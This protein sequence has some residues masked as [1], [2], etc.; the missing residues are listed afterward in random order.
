MGRAETLEVAG[1]AEITVYRVRRGPGYADKA[2]SPARRHFCRHCGSTLWASDPRWP[3]LVHPFASAIDTALPKAPER[4]H[5]MLDYVP[6]W[7]PVPEG[8]SDPHFSEYPDQSIH[9]W[10]QSRS[11]PIEE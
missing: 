4:C 6:A 1:G 2:R 3:E 7:V 8:G 9:D 11:L 10:H 5:I